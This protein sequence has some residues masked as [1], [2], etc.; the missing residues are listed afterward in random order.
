[1]VVKIEIKRTLNIRVITL[2]SKGKKFRPA[3]PAERA[4][5]HRKKS[6]LA[7]KPPKNMFL[8][9]PKIGNLKKGGF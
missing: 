8:E 2:Q 1:M 7:A 9:A 5:K 6:R 3:K 4:P